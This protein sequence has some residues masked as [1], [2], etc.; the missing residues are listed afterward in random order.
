VDSRAPRGATTIDEVRAAIDALTDADRLRLR[1]TASILLAGSDYSDPQDLLNEAVV[2]TLRAAA[3]QKGRHWPAGVDFIA[4]LVQTMKG[5]ASDS[6]ASVKV[7]PTRDLE[8]LATESLTADE[9]LGAHGQFHP[10]VVTLAIEAGEAADARDAAAE[11][12]AKIDAFF[13]GDEDVEFLIMG[14]RDE[15]TPQQVRKDAGLSQTQYETA[16]KR[17][18]RGLEK[19][20]PGRNA[21]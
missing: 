11:D 1:K 7:R 20:F 15:L 5:L 13:A 2:R 14:H 19:L 8:T 17:L 12:A 16:R 3:G 18:R 10:D 4:Y 9:G 21:K 6:R